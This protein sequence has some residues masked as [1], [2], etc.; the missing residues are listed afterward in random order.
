MQRL[1]DRGNAHPTAD[2]LLGGHSLCLPQ[3][4]FRLENSHARMASIS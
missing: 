1:P 2:E 4:G 3:Q